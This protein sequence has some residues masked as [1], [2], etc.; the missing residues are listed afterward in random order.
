MQVQTFYN[1]LL[2]NTQA[3][4]NAASGGAINNKTPEEAYELIEVMASKNYMKPS[5]RSFLRKAMGVHE[6]DGFTTLL[7]QLASIQK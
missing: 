5:D 7:A 1:D 3:M 4:V 2:P 6:V